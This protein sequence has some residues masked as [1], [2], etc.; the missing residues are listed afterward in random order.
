MADLT[1]VQSSQS[2]KIA[3]AAPSTGIENNYLDIDTTGRPT[4]KLNDGSGVAI[5]LGQTTMSA[6]LPVTIASN[7]STLNV[8]NSNFPS[9]VDI[10]YGTVGASTLRTA[11]QIGNA[12]GAALFG[13]GTTTA[14]VLRVVLPT[15][16]TSIPAVQSGTWNITNI[17]GTVSLPTGA[18][19]SANQTTIIT[20]LQLI[21]NPIGSVSAGTAGT[22]SFLTGGVFNT[23]LPSLTNTQQSATQL[24]SSGRI[25]I[26]PLTNSS[27]V[28]SQVQDNAGTGITSTLISA[29]QSL[30]VNIANS[31]AIP[32]T[33]KADGT[34]GTA[35]PG[36]TMQ[37]GGS[38]GT[39]LRTLKTDTSGNLFT[40]SKNPLTA[41][42][43]TSATVGVASAQAVATN[44]NR[45]GLVLINTSINKISFG[46]G[47][48]AVLNSGITLYPG[49][50]WVMDEFNLA[51]GAI[52]AIAGAASSNLSIQEFS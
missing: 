38:D 12:T 48:A 45:K 6:S 43:P 19:T 2:V 33:D 30:D 15:D 4:V 28:K 1:E 31:V 25:I 34:T 26:S 14:Q 50:V 10:N 36:T 27:I 3:G 39:N 8:T 18:S 5:N 22:S 20:S 11:S 17:S 35:V 7:Q 37:V 46:I 47:V 32:T 52:N 51:T 9:T 24:D 23:A 41:S 13:A 44:A 49:G 40:T 42:S 21:D 29:K 16:Q